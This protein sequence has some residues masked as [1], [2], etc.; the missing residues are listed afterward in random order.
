M[1]GNEKSPVF[2]AEANSTIKSGYRLTANDR[3][4]LHAK[5]MNLENKEKYVWITITYDYLDGVQ[6]D[7]RDGRMVYMSISPSTAGTC[8]GTPNSPFGASNLTIEMQ[9]KQLSFMEHSIPWVAPADG[10]ILMTGGHM[11]DGGDNTEI[12][13]NDKLICNSIPRYSKAITNSTMSGDGHGHKTRR[14]IKGGPLD[15]T[16][17]DHIFHQ[18]R[19][20][21]SEGIPLKKGDSMYLNA[22]YDFNKHPG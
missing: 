3:F 2:F 4:V 5:L 22:I 14:Q 19:C 12:F 13:H 15:N 9:P 7:Y 21:F 1:A 16:Q 20:T 17:I 18:N 8:P 6:P 11:H 10:L